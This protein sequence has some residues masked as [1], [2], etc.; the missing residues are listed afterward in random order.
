MLGTQRG[1]SRSRA[2]LRWSVGWETDVLRQLDHF[3]A[4]D[5][6]RDPRL[7]EAVEL[8][9]RRRGRDGRCKS[10]R[11]QAGALHFEPER[12]GTPSRLQGGH[13]S[14]RGTRG[15]RRS[16]S[17][18]R[19][20]RTFNPRIKSAV[21]AEPHGVDVAAETPTGQVTLQRRCHEV[22]DGHC[23]P[24]APSCSFCRAAG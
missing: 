9:R 22:A 15:L 13:G 18:G 8:S 6:P 20:T 3:V 7:A 10:T 5:V 24:A 2:R 21:A 14:C 1:V 16:G 11:P 19:R 17:E 23:Y 12:W 4:A